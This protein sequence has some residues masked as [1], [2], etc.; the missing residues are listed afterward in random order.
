MSVAS[1]DSRAGTWETDAPD[2][3]VGIVIYG[4][5]GGMLIKLDVLE[6]AFSS[7]LLELLESWAREQGA[8]GP[9]RP[10]MELVR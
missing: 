1:I 4:A 3:Y 9:A 2:G 7:E 8:L 5:D 6:S 10:T